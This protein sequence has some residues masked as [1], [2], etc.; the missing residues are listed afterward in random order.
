[1]KGSI[2]TPFGSVCLACEK[3]AGVWELHVDI[4]AGSTAQ[5]WIPY[6]NGQHCFLDGEEIEETSG[7]LESKTEA[8]LQADVKLPLKREADFLVASVPSGTYVWTVRG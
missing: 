4:P 6:R 2:L 5:V 1:M 3:K 7:L 8:V